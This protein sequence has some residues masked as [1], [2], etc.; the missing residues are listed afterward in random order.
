MRVSI[1]RG[2][3]LKRLVE[4]R[5]RFVVIIAAFKLKRSAG[6]VRA[7]EICPGQGVMRIDLRGLFEH[8]NGQWEVT[9]GIKI[10]AS[11]VI[12]VGQWT[13]GLI[14]FQTRC[15][16]RRE[17][18]LQPLNNLFRD[19]ILHCE[20]FLVSKVEGALPQDVAALHVDELASDAKV[21]TIPDEIPG[22]Q[23]V[24]IK[25]RSHFRNLDDLIA[26]FLDRVRRTNPQ[27][28]HIAKLGDDGIRK[29]I[30]E[31]I[32][33]GILLDILEGQ[34]RE[35]ARLRDRRVSPGTLTKNRCKPT[36]ARS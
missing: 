13:R 23:S 16:R 25:I 1:E 4:S 5:L 3:H 34:D 27:G 7:A 18:Q 28:L 36:A 29:R 10:H 6:R 30:A 20:Q 14:Q 26:I 15:F 9:P 8:L 11:Q 22:E 12:F 21:V 24:D 17:I 19:L 31:E 35:P 2:L 33:A 32:A